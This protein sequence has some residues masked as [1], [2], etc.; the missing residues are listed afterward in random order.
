MK[1]FEDKDFVPLYGAC[2]TLKRDLS[3]GV[4]TLEL[5][6]NQELCAKLNGGYTYLVLTSHE[7]PNCHEIVKVCQQN[8]ALFLERG[9]DNTKE[10]DWP[11]GA[12]AKYDTVPSGVWDMWQDVTRYERTEDD[13]CKSLYTGKFC[14]GRFD[15]SIKDGL[16]T[17]CRPN[18][19][20]IANACFENPVITFD[21]NGCIESV[22]EGNDKLV[23]YKPCRD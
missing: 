13:E 17:D 3:C 14:M 23:H 12:Q 15:F 7:Y 11:C 18:K 1:L 10:R 16:I 8:G 21:K 20:D 19:R 2:F 4:L 5:T 6:D 9:I 22:A